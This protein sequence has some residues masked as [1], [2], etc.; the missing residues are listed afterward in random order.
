MRIPRSNKLEAPEHFDENSLSPRQGSLRNR[1]RGWAAFC[2]VLVVALASAGL[3]VSP[4]SAQS[5]EGPSVRVWAKKL[6]SG[7]VEFGVAVYAAGSSRGVNVA[8]T[9][10]Y[11]PYARAGNNVGT[12]YN[13]EAVV[14]SSGADRALASIRA[15]RLA[16]GNLEFAL[17]VYGIEDQVWN[18]RARYLIYASAVEDSAAFS[19]PLYFRQHNREC[20][21]GAV[22]NVASNLGLFRDCEVL[23]NATGPLEGDTGILSGLNSWG[24]TQGS[25]S[26]L[27]WTGITLTNN[28]VTHL[29]LGYGRSW[30]PNGN[31][32]EPGTCRSGAISISAPLL[33]S[34]ENSRLNRIFRDGAPLR[35]LE[36]RIPGV[37][38]SLSALERLWIEFTGT[39]GVIPPELGNLSN[40]K[41]LT[42]HRIGMIGPIPPELGNLKNLETLRLS[43]LKW[44]GMG[45]RCRT[46]PT[47]CGLPDPLPS[48]VQS[49]LQDTSGLSGSIP[50][51]LGDMTNLK[52]L[53]L[54]GNLLNGSI[55]AELGNL[56][57]LETLSLV[58]NWIV[59]EIPSELG[60]LTNLKSLTLNANKLTGQ[61][62]ASLGNLTNLEELALGWNDLSGPIPAELANLHPDNG[63]SIKK[64]SFVGTQGLTMQFGGEFTEYTPQRENNQRLGCIPAIFNDP[65]I[66]VERSGVTNEGTKSSPRYERVELPF[67]TS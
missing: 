13:S 66:T 54:D 11:F 65:D 5:T 32:W 27:P 28:R 29:Y 9:N 59:G 12:W 48:E 15:R 56:E 2:V 64:I 60:D 10:R 62:P 57:N 49:F 50:S 19:S 67:C 43:Y 17:K 26:Q 44:V 61:I 1:R 46:A 63:G 4:T 36:G 31:A 47:E 35:S 24:T 22:P 18:P 8:V 34:P 55:P 42:L 52:E 51:E 33:S 3:S 37:L 30:C 20:L 6:A 38:G 41:E 53:Y 45:S 14:L 21:D 25:V 58:H 23:L 16:S 7:N 40:L 39:Q